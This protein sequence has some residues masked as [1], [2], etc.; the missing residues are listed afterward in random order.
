MNCGQC[1]KVTEN[2]GRMKTE[3][4]I[5]EN[6]KWFRQARPRHDD[7]ACWGI[8]TRFWKTDKKEQG[9]WSDYKCWRM[10]D[11]FHRDPSAF[12]KRQDK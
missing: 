12:V 3:E 2:R 5:C 10:G 11:H 9:T 8:C 1:G 7:G 4:A 6:C